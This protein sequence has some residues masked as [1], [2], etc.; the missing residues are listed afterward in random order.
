[1]AR[2]CDAKVHM[3]MYVHA[4]VRVYVHKYGGKMCVERRATSAAII[5]SSTR[6]WVALLYSYMHTLTT[7]VHTNYAYRRIHTIPA[8]TLK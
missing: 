8:M 7:H 6:T 2:K 5:E 1:M 4:K 3:H